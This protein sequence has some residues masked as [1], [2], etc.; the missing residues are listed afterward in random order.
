MEMLFVRGD[1]VIL[2][3]KLSDCA[4]HLLTSFIVMK[5]SPPART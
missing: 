4:I 5:V 3:C 1:G 2:V